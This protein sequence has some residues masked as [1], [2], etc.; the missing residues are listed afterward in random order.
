MAEY[1]SN[2]AD[3]ILEDQH[4]RDPNVVFIK[5]TT[6]VVVIG[7]VSTYFIMAYLDGI[8]TR[9]GNNKKKR[10]DVRTT[11]LISTPHQCKYP[12]L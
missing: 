10:N 1:A 3:V 2:N 5:F 9:I 11:V 4:Q 7:M 8:P 6:N 12:S